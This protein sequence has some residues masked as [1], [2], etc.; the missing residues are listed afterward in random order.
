MGTKICSKCSIV[1]DICE[2]HK[3]IH[4]KDGVRNTCKKCRKLESAKN[5]EYRK[6]NIE[7]IKHKNKLWFEKNP[8]YSKNYQKEYNLK[9]RK[10]LNDKLKKWR[11]IKKSN[12][13]H[14]K[15]ENLKRKEKYNKDINYRLRQIFR[16][17]INKIIKFGRGKKS[18]VLLGCTLEEFRLYIENKF[19]DGMS[20]DNYGY[21]GWHLDHIIPLS[22]VI[23]EEELHK[24]FHYTNLQPMWAIDNI[25]KSNKII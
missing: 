1:K 14:L 15:K 9:N 8:T 24:L 16:T 22:I 3:F 12:P 17:R 4:S 23:N 20:W 2:F 6:K 7:N 25:K 21:R 18:L 10:K 11:D 5:S 13:I 19:Q